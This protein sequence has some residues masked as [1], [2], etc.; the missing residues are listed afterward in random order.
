MNC[1]SVFFSCSLIIF[2]LVPT[3]FLKE[4]GSY[5]E[6]RTRTYT[7]YIRHKQ[8]QNQ[9]GFRVFMNYIFRVRNFPTSYTPS[10]LLG[11]FWSEMSVKCFLPKYSRQN[12]VWRG[13]E[14]LKFSIFVCVRYGYTLRCY[15]Y[16]H[17]KFSGLVDQC[18][19]HNIIHNWS[20]TSL[21]HSIEEFDV[22]QIWKMLYLL[23]I[24]AITTDRWTIEKTRTSNNMMES[25]NDLCIP[26]K[27]IILSGFRL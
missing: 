22:W 18:I 15:K 4:F 16:R 11:I 24:A 12:V 23:P 10:I 13:L 5:I 3:H 2:S 26:P 25:L 27:W 9:M 19:I 14:R 1:V 17:Y 21:T 7:K 6:S 20:T 8:R